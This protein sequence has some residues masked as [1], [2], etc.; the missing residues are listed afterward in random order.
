M[1]SNIT[2]APNIYVRS[3]VNIQDDDEFVKKVYGHKALNI[4][5]SQFSKN[6]SSKLTRAQIEEMKQNVICRHG[7]TREYA[8]G[9]ALQDGDKIVWSCRCEHTD[10]YAYDKCMSLPNAMK[11]KRG[12]LSAE[13]TDKDG[14]GFENEQDDVFEP[15]H[16]SVVLPILNEVLKG[17]DMQVK[18][19]ILAENFGV[20]PEFDNKRVLVICETPCELGYLSTL[21]YKNS[22]KHRTLKSEGYTLHRRIADVFWDY[23]KDTIDR[24]AF[25]NRCIVRLGESDAELSAFYNALFKLCGD[26][27]NDV[28]QIS[29]LAAA[30]DEAPQLISKCVLNMD[31]RSEVFPVTVSVLETL[32]VKDEYD[33]V[34][35]LEG[36]KVSVMSS[37]LSD[38]FG[39]PPVIIQKETKAGWLFN[40]S[41]L[42]RPYRI[43]QDNYKG[44][45]G[46][47]CLNVEL[48]LWWD[49]DGKS[50]LNDHMGDAIRLQLYIAEKIKT[51][52][53]LTVEKNTDTGGYWFYHNGNILGEIPSALIREVRA[54]EGFPDGF[55]GFEG[56]YVRNIVTCISDKDD[57]TLPARFKDS[58]VWLGLDITGYAKVLI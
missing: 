25:F 34:Y 11:I 50:F 7:K 53:E 55:M 33:E 44:G 18:N 3:S 35:L 49:I 12:G 9:I 43:S 13:E 20:G 30:L 16:V 15:P 37:A 21:L 39:S 58:R 4:L 41:P 47:H 14:Y 51:G 28:L 40:K 54:I 19:V 26:T 24:D 2:I 57:S 8:Y 6:Y 36:E 23:C 48:G 52:D 38:L 46:Q 10:C 31:G 17:D 5:K 42:G 29:K 27:E 45:R 56:I 1:N 32:N 22:V